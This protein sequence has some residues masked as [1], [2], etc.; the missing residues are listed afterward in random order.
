MRTRI[1]ALV[2]GIVYLLVGLA[3]FVLTDERDIPDLSV[4]RGEGDLLGLFPVNV[5]HNLTHILLGAW[6]VAASR[7]WDSAR[8][9]ARGQA[10]IYGLLAIMGLIPGMNTTFGLIP[11]FGH[12]VWLHA[13]IAVAAAY[14]GWAARSRAHDRDMAGAG[15]H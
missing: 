7:A 10:I 2:V 13:L 3:G 14:F 1:F 11:I 8:L 9:Y 15:R 5:L 6:G 4:H 12:D